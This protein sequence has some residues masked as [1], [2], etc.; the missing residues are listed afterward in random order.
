MI[1]N[2]RIWVT[3][4][5]GAAMSMVRGRL[6]NLEKLENILFLDNMCHEM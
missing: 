5:G 4:S 2:A 3:P 6:E 1:E